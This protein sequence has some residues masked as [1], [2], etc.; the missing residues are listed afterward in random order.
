MF[1]EQASILRR[2]E[3]RPGRR[4]VLT[5]FQTV[6]KSAGASNL[7]TLDAAVDALIGAADEPRLISVEEAVKLLDLAYA[8]LEFPA[9][10]MT[11][12]DKRTSL[13]LSTYRA[14]PKILTSKAKRG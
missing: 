11:M 12:I 9:T 5:G 14:P 7:R 4:L 6:S 2:C 1:A 8:N 10:P 3:I 13:P